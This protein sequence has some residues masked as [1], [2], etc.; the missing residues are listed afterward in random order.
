MSEWYYTDHGE[1]RG[2][3][4]EERIAAM[5]RSGQLADDT[6]VW[7]DELDDWILA[8]DMEPYLPPPV[9]TPPPLSVATSQPPPLGEPVPLAP[10]Y[11]H[12]SVGRLL[13][14]SL[15]SSGLYE[16]YWIYKNWRYVKERDGQQIR[17]FWRAVF[18]IFF[19]YGIMKKIHEDKVMNRVEPA[20]FPMGLLAGGWI[21]SMIVINGL[22]NSENILIGILCM[23]FPSF[24]FFVPVQNYINRVTAKL[25][26]A[27]PYTPWT[28]GHIVCLLFGIALWALILLGMLV[29]E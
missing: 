14:L 24:L 19:V 4:P 8:R 27:M 22:S 3:V 21:G 15:I 29:G 5:R 6:L 12:V 18:G 26:D 2:P 9:P 11:L 20:S 23:I 25:N 10:L 28:A 13:F 1:Q 17:P 7:M 16:M